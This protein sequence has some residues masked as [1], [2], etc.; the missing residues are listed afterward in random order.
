M[1][2]LYESLLDVDQ[3]IENVTK[4]ILLKD[5]EDI[6]GPRI[7]EL[8]RFNWDSVL[9]IARRGYIDEE[10]LETYSRAAKTSIN[11]AGKKYAKLLE[12]LLKPIFLRKSEKSLEDIKNEFI[13]TDY[14]KDDAWE[15][16]PN[17]GTDL[18]EVEI[19]DYIALFEDVEIYMNE[20]YK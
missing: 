12:K 20:K 5:Y 1:K 8:L 6:V 18:F 16:A 14:F 3:N 15:W 13:N 17:A 11:S 7:K 10:G 19:M 2:G 4:N 9:A